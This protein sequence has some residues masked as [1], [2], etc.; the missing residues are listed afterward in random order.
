MRVRW[1][2]YF[3][4]FVCLC[5][6]IAVAGNDQNVLFGDDAVMLGGAVTAIVEGGAGLWYNP[7]GI[8]RA[9]LRTLDLN[10][11]AYSLNNYR[12]ASLAR[13]VSG[14][15]ADTSVNEI[16]VIPTSLSW[17]RPVNNSLRIA[18]GLFV[19]QKQDYVLNTQLSADRPAGN[20]ID[21]VLDQSVR[22]ARY[23]AMTGLARRF[24]P[25]LR[26]GVTLQA[27]YLS[28]F[29]STQAATA[30]VEASTLSSD[31]FVVQTSQANSRFVGAA[32]SAG[33]QWQPKSR[34]AVGLSIVSPFVQLYSSIRDST[35]AISH[36][37]G[38]PSSAELGG[39]KNS[40]I[41]LTTVFPS[42]IRLGTALT[43]DKWGMSLDG[44][45]TFGM[46]DQDINVDRISVWNVQAG[47]Y[48]D[49]HSDIRIG[50]GFFTDRSPNAT[51]EE[52]GDYKVDFYGVSLGLSFDRTRNLIVPSRAKTS[53]CWEPTSA[54]AMRMGR[55][56]YGGFLM[57]DDF[58]NQEDMFVTR[59][60]QSTGH[61][62]GLYVGS[63]LRF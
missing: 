23:H 22:L 15:F 36:G 63:R 33:V 17:V 60:A 32:V 30:L 62:F 26:L 5:P 43:Y 3:F 40:D 44:S 9:Q 20:R 59:N 38:A 1:L 47:V 50:G 58:Q 12:V 25:H 10:T 45:Y 61:E 41:G 54:F 48:T 27:A 51:V 24:G 13:F 53:F 55:G 39:T 35:I 29:D 21:L 34:I 28:R 2:S 37:I 46:Q 14:E 8:A 56:D 31:N 57:R 11:T 18:A 4:W 16:V 49:I 52:Y 42:K 7:A 6:C 19:A